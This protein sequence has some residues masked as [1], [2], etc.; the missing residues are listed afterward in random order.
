MAVRP[1]LSLKQRA[2]KALAFTKIHRIINALRL[3]THTH[4]ESQMAHQSLLDSR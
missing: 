4:L 3:T 2:F 1:Q